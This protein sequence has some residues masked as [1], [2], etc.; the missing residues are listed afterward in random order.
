MKSKNVV[1]RDTSVVVIGQLITTATM[2]GIFALLG[3]FDTSLLLGGIAGAAVATANF[4]FMA[5]FA[6]L[7]ADKAAAQDVSGGQKLIQL[8]YLGRMLGLFAVLAICA[9]SDLF[10]VLALVIPLAFT[11]PILTFAEIFKKKGDETA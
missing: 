1:F 11:R 5:L 2:I 3:K 4:Y 10:N 9:R 6:N 8:S 7:A